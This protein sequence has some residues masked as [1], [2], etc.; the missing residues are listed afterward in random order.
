MLLIQNK[1]LMVVGDRFQLNN[2]DWYR[3]TSPG[4]NEPLVVRPGKVTCE[5]LRVYARSSYEVRYICR[6]CD[7]NQRSD[8]FVLG[9]FLIDAYEVTAKAEGLTVSAMVF[10]EAKARLGVRSISEL[11]PICYTKE[12]AEAIAAEIRRMK[13]KERYGYLVPDLDA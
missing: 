7:T 10:C 1:E 3:L 5:V 13:L 9:Q 2:V 4:C 11:M 8:E 6:R 12:D